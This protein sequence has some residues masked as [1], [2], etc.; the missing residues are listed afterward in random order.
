MP[1]FAAPSPSTSSAGDKTPLAISTDPTIKEHIPKPPRV[2]PPEVLGASPS[3]AIKEK[4]DAF[5][6]ALTNFVLDDK[7][8][9][10]DTFRLRRAWEIAYADLESAVASLEA[11]LSQA[12]TDSRLLDELERL[13]KNGQLEVGDGAYGDGI[14]VICNDQLLRPA[15]TLKTLR[16]AAS[17]SLSNRKENG[18]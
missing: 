6:L 8:S 17:A 15:H 1:T 3:G 12:E 11:R 9:T 4:I 13:H 5:G 14:D 18:E 7:E 16:E 2:S 10:P